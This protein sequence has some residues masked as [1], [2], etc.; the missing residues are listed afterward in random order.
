MPLFKKGNFLLQTRVVQHFSANT[1][2]LPKTNKGE[3]MRLRSSQNA[4]FSIMFLNDANE[5][6]TA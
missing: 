3:K 1:I 2:W 5:M 6:L 4:K